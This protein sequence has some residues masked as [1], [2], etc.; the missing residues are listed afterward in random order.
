MSSPEANGMYLTANCGHKEALNLRE[1]ARCAA[2]AISCA[3]QR[4]GVPGYK[5]LVY[6]ELRGCF[7]LCKRCTPLTW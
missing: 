4:R 6:T 7:R 5:Q 3:V 1:Q 2:H